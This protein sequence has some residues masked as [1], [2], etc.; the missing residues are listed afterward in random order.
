MLDKTMLSF[1]SQLYLMDLLLTVIFS[2][3]ATF[4]LS[5]CYHDAMLMTSKN[6][7]RTKNTCIIV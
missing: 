1:H 3:Y 7:L 5:D 6:D 2:P 4:L